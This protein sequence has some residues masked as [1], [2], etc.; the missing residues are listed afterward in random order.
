MAC[1]YGLLSYFG[2]N[3]RR[4]RSVKLVGPTIVLPVPVI[5]LLAL[6]EGSQGCR[7]SYGNTRVRATNGVAGRLYSRT[8]DVRTR[9]TSR[10]ARPGGQLRA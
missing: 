3:L 5:E 6:S 10:L 2:W 9:R 1:R 7:R 8:V 4:S